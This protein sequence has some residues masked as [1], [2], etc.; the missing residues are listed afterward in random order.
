MKQI[1]RQTIDSYS[2]LWDKVIKQ[3]SKQN[4]T[5][6]ETLQNVLGAQI[7][8]VGVGLDIGCGAGHDIEYMAKTHPNNKFVAIDITH[9]IY[10]VKN[11]L[12]HL[13]NIQ[14]IRASA[15]DL[16]FKKESFDFIY[17]FGV[18]HHTADPAKGLNEINRVLKEKTAAVLYLYGNHEDNIVKFYALKIIAGIRKI[19]IKIPVKILFALCII[20]SPVVFFLFSVPS[21]LLNKFNKTKFIAQKLPFNFGRHPFGLATHLFDR[22]ATPIEIRYGKRELTAA[23]KKAKFSNFKLNKVVGS[24]AG[25]VVWSEK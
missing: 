22:F 20:F 24:V 13:H 11:R 14:F 15:L 23:I 18:L 17:S 2:F 6:F 25:W 16:P 3:D 21:R 10:K 19:T 1:E 8:K 12:K 5:H 7:I 9:S 4:K